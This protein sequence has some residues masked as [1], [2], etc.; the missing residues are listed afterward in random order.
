MLKHADTEF[1]NHPERVRGLKYTYECYRVQLYLQLRAAFISLLR[2]PFVTHFRWE[3]LHRYI[4]TGI[5]V[6]YIESE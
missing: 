3:I 2:R 1:V 5:L 6:Y 4:G